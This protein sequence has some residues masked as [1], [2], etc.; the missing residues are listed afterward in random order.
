MGQPLFK[1]GFETNKQTNM[2]RTYPLGLFLLLEPPL[3]A[4]PSD[5]FVSLRCRFLLQAIGHTVCIRYLADHK[6][7]SSAPLTRPDNI[8]NV[9]VYMCGPAVIV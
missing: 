7:Y 2:Q 4:A 3:G 9:C 6:T 5:A 1:T 8:Y